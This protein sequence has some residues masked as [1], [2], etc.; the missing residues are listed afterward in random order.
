MS[1]VNVRSWWLAG[2][3]MVMLQWKDEM[4]GRPPDR[5]VCPSSY[6]PQSSSYS[7]AGGKQPPPAAAVVVVGASSCYLSDGE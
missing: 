2:V 7:R 4:V 3:Y 1:V 6:F 5:P